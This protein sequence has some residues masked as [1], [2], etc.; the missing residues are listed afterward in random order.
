MFFTYILQSL[1][2]QSFY[3]GF[4]SNLEQRLIKHNNAKTGYTATKKPWKIVYFETFELES[5]A[6]K[7]ERAIKKKKSRKHIEFLIEQW[8]EPSVD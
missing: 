2:D 8:N 5:D 6:R 1:K 7:R 3:I 4:S